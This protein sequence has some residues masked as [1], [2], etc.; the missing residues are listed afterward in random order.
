[1]SFVL[2]ILLTITLLVSVETTNASRNNDQ[3]LARENARLAILIAIGNVQQFAGPD[4][5]ITA[6]A[7]IL[8]DG[9]YNENSKFWTGLWDS[10]LAGGVDPSP[11]WL[12]SGDSPDP[13]AGAGAISKVMFPAT[14]NEPE[15]RVPLVNIGDDNSPSGE[16]AFWVIDE[17]VK[18]SA[19]ARRNAVPTYEAPALNSQRRITEYQ[20]AF[21]VGLNSFF[22]GASLDIEE[23]DFANSLSKVFNIE[24]MESVRDSDDNPLRPSSGDFIET[25]HSLTTTAFG[26]LENPLEGGLKKNLSDTTYRDSFLATDEMQEFLAPKGGFLDVESGLPSRRFLTGKPYYSPRPLLTE[27]ALYIGVFHAD[28]IGQLR[29]RYHMEAEFINPYSLPLRFPEDTINDSRFPNRAMVLLFENL[30]TITVRDLTP[31]TAAPE[32]SEDLNKFAYASPSTNLYNINSWFE[33]LPTGTPNVPVLNPG[34]TY[35]V[36]EPR[37]SQTEGLARTFNG[38][39][40]WS[41]NQETKPDDDADIE[42]RAIHPSNPVTLSVVPFDPS[43]EYGNPEGRAP[44]LKFEGLAFND[45]RILKKFNTGTNP[46]SR[47]TSGGYE[48]VDYIFA[49]HFRVR[50]DAEDFTSMQDV[51]TAVD[52]RDPDIDADDLFTDIAGESKDTSTIFDSIESDPSFA[53]GSKLGIF[54]DLDQL[55]DNTVRARA[56]TDRKSLIYDIPDGDVLS[57]GQLSSLHIYRRKPRSIGSPWG[58]D[59]NEAFDRYY[60]SPKRT[61]PATSEVILSSP[62]LVSLVSPTVQE[63]QDDALN[64]LTVGSFNINSTSVEAW[65]A[66]LA[67]PVLTPEALDEGSGASIDDVSRGGAF[68]RMPQY[69][70]RV[71]EFYVT[72]EQIQ[73]AADRFFGQ[74]IRSLEGADGRLQLRR[75]AENIVEQLKTKGEPFSDMKTFV[76]SGILRDAIDE[77]DTS[78]STG[79]LPAVNEN[80][81]EY[82]NVYLTQNDILTKI[83]PQASTRSDTF[84]IRAYGA[85]NE[86]LTGNPGSAVW[87]EATVQ[88]IPEKMDGADPMTP[89]GVDSPRKF[90]IIN[91]RWLTDESS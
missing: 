42:I 77:T 75:I 6:R 53:I 44:I 67:S 71:D 51:L 74:G 22:D 90:Q 40:I 78:G 9:N 21:G 72:P 81:M 33:I 35:Q 76:N 39:L 28:S 64:E 73:D 41:N 27:A 13:S 34:E 69:Q 14:P 26:V 7:D 54:S 11:V 16:Y 83:A 48:K 57:V 89:A 20:A 18:A 30:P 56:V 55:F 47:P 29:I 70:A 79:T 12:V 46:F 10:D 45:F 1:M 19:S 82:S 36:L 91:I 87:C 59:Y 58:E 37:G 50:S 86:S 49:Y 25:Q 31:D 38:N 88:R 32:L 17:G 60:F 62:A 24:D 80:I 66:V 85:T 2:M 61:N 52:L 65:E 43:D 84:K 5:K 8:G 68:F 15:V 23:V 4:L 63:D 3:L